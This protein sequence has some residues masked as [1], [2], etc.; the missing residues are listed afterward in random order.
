MLGSR[1]HDEQTTPHGRMHRRQLLAGLAG[2]GAVAFAGGPFMLQPGDTGAPTL[3][4]AP[5]PGAW[6][7]NTRPGGELPI[8]PLYSPPMQNGVR[9]FDL[10]VQSGQ[11]AFEPGRPASTLGVNSPY[12]GPTL[13]ASQGENVA[14]NIVNS[15]NDATAL[16]WH[17]MHLP[18]I[19][20]G[21]PHQQIAP[22]ALWQPTWTIRQPGATLWYHSHLMGQTRAQLTRG[23]AGMFI[24]DDASPIEA[25]L[26][27]TYGVDDIPLIFQDYLFG[28]AR[29]L[30]NGG[31]LPLLVA[32]QPRLRL[33]LLNASNQQLL[34]IGF[35]GDAPFDQVASDGGLLNTPVRLTR[36]VLGP[37]ERIEIVV[38]LNGARLALQY[39][40]G[41][42]AGA[43]VG[44]PLLWIQPPIKQA[45][46]SSI[47]CRAS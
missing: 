7:D 35:S 24:V 38:D 4:P 13:R 40:E 6:L 25:D 36:V 34:R 12:L 3:Q 5:A 33:R 30:V 47:R 27:S 9:I 14:F 8:P 22:G 41:D 45:A 28:G 19:M 43:A 32:R 46:H 11:V 2:A 29:I 42:G 39:F 26:P 16:H 31:L 10:T 21:N 23:L 17:G 1:A 37:A 20:D 15:L 18:A 44:T